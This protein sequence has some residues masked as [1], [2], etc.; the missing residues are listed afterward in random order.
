MIRGSPDS[1][2]GSRVARSERYVAVVHHASLLSQLEMG[3]KG[4]A[5]LHSP[6]HVA[7]DVHALRTTRWR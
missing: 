5:L 3:W 6:H 1:I 7:A 4:Q 2:D